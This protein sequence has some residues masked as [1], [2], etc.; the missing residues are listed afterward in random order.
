[1]ALVLFPLVCILN[2]IK[3][4]R[5][6]G[7]ACFLNKAMASL[8]RHSHTWFKFLYLLLRI[9]IINELFYSLDCCSRMVYSLQTRSFRQFFWCKTRVIYGYFVIWS[10]FLLPFCYFCLINAENWKTR[11][12]VFFSIIAINALCIQRMIDA[13]SFLLNKFFLEGVLS[14]TNHREKT[15]RCDPGIVE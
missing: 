8:T 1:M 9:G 12:L 14:Q 13:L 11:S 6:W 15:R 5:R 10:T 3:P 4:W 7:M 2:G